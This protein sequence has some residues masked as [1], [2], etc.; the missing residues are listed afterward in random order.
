MLIH[1]KEVA[2]D[3]LRTRF[4]YGLVIW[5]VF[6]C[7]LSPKLAHCY[8]IPVYSCFRT[9]NKCVQV[10]QRWRKGIVKARRSKRVVVNSAN[11]WRMRLKHS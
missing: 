7:D 3:F 8:R 11:D 4:E 10:D 2:V 5:C 9:M 1:V 6:P